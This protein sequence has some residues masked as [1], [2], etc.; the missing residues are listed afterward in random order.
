VPGKVQRPA[1]FADEHVLTFF[2]RLAWSPDGTALLRLPW[3]VPLIS[4]PPCA[5]SPHWSRGCALV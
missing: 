4:T 3:L 2:R 5:R 1:L